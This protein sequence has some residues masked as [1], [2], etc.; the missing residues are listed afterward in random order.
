MD[1]LR[2]IP[3]IVIALVLIYILGGGPVPA[4]DRHRASHRRRAG[5]AV[6]RSGRK[7]RSETGRGAGLGRR[8]LGASRCGSAS[9]RRSRPNWLSYG[10]LRFEINMRAS[11][12]LGF[13]GSG[14]I[15]YDLKVAMQW[16]RG[17]YDQVVAI[18]LM[19]FLTIVAVRPG[20]RAATATVW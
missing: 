15:G 14:G 13:V 19:L 17:S 1:A 3:E 18:F 2:A 6:L 20:L 7:C 9:C 5:Q 12:I 4:D 8:D 16:G 10:L 11:A